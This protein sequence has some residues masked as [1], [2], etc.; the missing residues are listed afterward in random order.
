MF[1]MKKILLAL[2]IIVSISTAKA[3]N[4]VDVDLTA[5]FVSSTIWRGSYL[6]GASVQPEVSVGWRGL[7]LS[8]WGSAGVADGRY[9]IDLTLSYTIGG[10]T[11][12]VVD[13]WDNTGGTSFFY[14]KPKST[15]H[16]FEG[17]IEYDFGPVAASWQ[18][19]FAGS[20]YQ[21]ADDKRAF[22]SYFEISAPF[23]LGGLEWIA[24]AGVVPWASDYYDTK[25]FS[26]KCVS[27]KATKDIQITEKFV[28]P[29]YGELSADPFARNLYFVAGFTLKAF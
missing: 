28:L 10:L 29:L 19:F 17:A 5:D 24:K 11:L 23:H 6:G 2:L 15:G 1:K 9:E 13:Y 27:L 20:D 16:S 14:F 21:E 26:L 4:E 3:Q 8:A 25:G 7:E 22:S 18:T 12:S